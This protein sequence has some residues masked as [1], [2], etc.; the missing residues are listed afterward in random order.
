MSATCRIAGVART[1][2]YD[3]IDALQELNIVV[4]TREVGGGPMYEINMDS[5]L[6]EHIMRVEGLAGREFAERESIQT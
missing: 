5:E 1:T 6:V 3:H 4:K 2:V